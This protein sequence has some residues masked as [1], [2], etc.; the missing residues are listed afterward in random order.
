M[1]RPNRIGETQRELKSEYEVHHLFY[2]GVVTEHQ[3]FS[4]LVNY[5]DSILKQQRVIVKL[6]NR[7]GA[8]TGLSNPNTMLQRIN[9]L[10]IWETFWFPFF[11]FSK[12][13]L[14][15]NFFMILFIN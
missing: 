15:F 8:E 4:Y 9:K 3:Y 11:I 6:L 10:I 14:Y 5:N 13:L 1:R 7:Y 2:E 12:F